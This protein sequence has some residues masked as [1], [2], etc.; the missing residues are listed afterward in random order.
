MPSYVT[1]SLLADG[2]GQCL[3]NDFCFDLE[4]FR[5]FS[6]GPDLMMPTN[7]NVF[8]RNHTENVDMFFYEQLVYIKKNMLHENV[9]VLMFLYGQITHYVL[10]SVMHPYI[11]YI[12]EKVNDKGNVPFHALFEMWLDD[13]LAKKHNIKDRDNYVFKGNVTS[14]ELVKYIDATYRKV[15]KSNT[16]S[17]SYKAGIKILSWF[18]KT[19]RKDKSGKKKKLYRDLGVG[20]LTIDDHNIT[21]YLNNEHNDWLH[22]VT[23]HKKNDSLDELYSLALIRSMD[24]ICLVNSYLYDKVSISYVMRHFDNL[25]YDTGIDC[26]DKRK[27]KYFKRG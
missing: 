25:S 9:D 2:V 5:T 27:M 1:H 17:K 6:L 19:I 21:N 20:D 8:H 18:E 13:Y 23:G 14:K 22:P 15:Y 16:V 7:Y 4:C 10:D 12:T 26:K 3:K 24:L 11:Y